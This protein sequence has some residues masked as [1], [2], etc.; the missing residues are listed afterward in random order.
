MYPQCTGLLAIFAVRSYAVQQSTTRDYD[1]FS[2]AP[3]NYLNETFYIYLLKA[4]F[5]FIPLVG[6]SQ[7]STSSI[8]TIGFMELTILGLQK[9]LCTFNTPFVFCWIFF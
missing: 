1:F 9:G 6:S 4:S 3:N 8:Y 5:K 2:R 7:Y